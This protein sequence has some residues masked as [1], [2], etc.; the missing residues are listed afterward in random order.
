MKEAPGS[1][2]TSVLTSA[3]RR[4]NPEDTILQEYSG[5]PISSGSLFD[6]SL[7]HAPIEMFYKVRYH[8]MFLMLIAKFMKW[9]ELG[10]SYVPSI[11]LSI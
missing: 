5:L 4:N 3:T 10:V 1:S 8:K 2:E 7:W 6:K 9:K 11:S